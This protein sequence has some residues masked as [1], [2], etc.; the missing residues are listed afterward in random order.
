M[1]PCA[2]PSSL[3]RR[4]GMALKWDFPSAQCCRPYFGPMNA[5]PKAG[6]VGALLANHRHLL[7]PCDI[8][9]CLAGPSSAKFIPSLVPWE[10]DLLV[11]FHLPLVA[12]CPSCDFH[13]KWTTLASKSGQAV[14]PPPGYLQRWF[15]NSR[16]ARYP[17][18]TAR[19]AVN[20]SVL[21]PD[22]VR[23][24]R[25]YGSAKS[26]HAREGETLRPGVGDISGCDSEGQKLRSLS[27]L[28]PS[29]S[30]SFWGR[31][32]ET[33]VTGAR[34]RASPG[35]PDGTAL[36]APAERTCRTEAVDPCW[37]YG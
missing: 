15:A 36:S 7:T 13:R 21:W 28:F 35:P 6:S 17:A 3:D 9:P 23:A 22:D 33:Q 25:G 19:L 11:S 32:S 4:S 8:P 24:E 12:S 18:P 5:M 29:C 30:S 34:V 10:T 2:G 27:L 1:R 14:A 20:V 37:R 31:S 16:Q 26:A